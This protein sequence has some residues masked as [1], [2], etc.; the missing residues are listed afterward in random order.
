M[1]EKII[2]T[3]AFISCLIF[4]VYVSIYIFLLIV[5]DL[6]LFIDNVERHIKEW[7]NKHGKIL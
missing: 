4:V 2:I 7:Y 5:L 1:F 3:L 6:I